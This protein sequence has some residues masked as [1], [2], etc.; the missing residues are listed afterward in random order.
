MKLTNDL[1]HAVRSLLREPGF[2]VPATLMLGLGL[3]AT[4]V[5]FSL[6]NGVLLKPLPYAQPDRL[7]SIREVLP[8]TPPPAPAPAPPVG[9]WGAPPQPRPC[10]SCVPPPPPPLRR[11]AQV[12]PFAGE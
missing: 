4:S 7:V 12:L 3:G 8:R 10:V 1:S 11:V 5:V 9:V 2:A 6:V